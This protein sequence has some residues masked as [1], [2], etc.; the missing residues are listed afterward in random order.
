[1]KGKY[2][3]SYKIKAAYSEP[4]FAFQAKNILLLL[5]AFRFNSVIQSHKD[6][7]MFLKYQYNML[8]TC[9]TRVGL[10]DCFYADIC[11]QPN[12]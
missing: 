8:Q 9:L 4:N 2:L 12:H 11:L 6:H 5:F 7:E 1:M 10:R 3:K